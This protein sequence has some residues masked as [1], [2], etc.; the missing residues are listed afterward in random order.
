MRKFLI[1]YILFLPLFLFAAPKKHIDSRYAISKRSSRP[2][3]VIDPGHGGLDLGTKS[4]APY[5][6]EKRVALATAKLTKR[7][8]DQLGYQV[9]LT[10]SSDVFIPL[11]R[12]VRMA[13]RGRCA[14]FVSIHYNSSPNSSAHGVEVFFCNNKKGT[15]RAKASK[16]LAQSLLNNVIKRTKAKSRGIKTANFYVIRETKV[17]AVLVEGGFI[18]NSQERKKLKQNN[19]LD[20]I[21]RGIADGVDNYFKS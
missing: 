11:G 19:Y 2:L 1:L 14:L 20:R 16:K 10:R 3:I 17:P 6:E 21:A 12:R 8:L 9:V 4:R 13:N 5:C 15:T 18:S 7:Y